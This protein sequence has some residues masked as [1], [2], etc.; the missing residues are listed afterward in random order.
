MK[1]KS[2]YLKVQKHLQKH[3]DDTFR[4]ILTTSLDSVILEGISKHGKR[5]IAKH[6]TRWIVF[7]QVDDSYV[8]VPENFEVNSFDN[9]V[10]RQTI[11]I[12]MESDKDFNIVDY[13]KVEI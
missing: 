9:P 7:G 5:L 1:A 6:G 12:K 10:F 13:R 3:L 8:I 11:S 4:R 2:D